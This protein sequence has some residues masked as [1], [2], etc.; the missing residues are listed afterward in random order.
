MLVVDLDGTLLDARGRVSAA[1]AA[2][3]RR[4]EEAGVEV[5]V[6][7]GRSWLESRGALTAI[8]SRGLM[9]GAGGATL[10]EAES[11]RILARRT[12]ET[13]LVERICDSLLR[14]GHLA[15]LLQDPEEAGRDYTLIGEAG[16]DP[17]S[18]WWFSVHPVRL[19]RHRS[20]D[21]A[22]PLGATIRVGTVA[23]DAE[24]ARVAGELREDLGDLVHLQHWSAQTAH[25]TI[26][27]RTHLLEI[28]SRDT[29]KWTMVRELLRTRD[30][31]PEAV[32]SVGDGLNDL[33]LVG[34]AGFGIAMGNAD[35]RV[36]AV[37]RATV[38]HHDRDGFAEA[39]DLLL[40][41]GS[42]P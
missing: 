35:P 25:E 4:A 40:G 1:N 5:V 7:T 42:R 24:L 28:F 11:G 20:I 39:V 37:A 21:E 16:L 9:I 31:G 41:A 22:R 6:A 19:H 29:N 2:A 14:H 3:V 34:S 36:A 33:Q 12:V 30:F 15:H 23:V 17:A 27:S 18:E 26:G 32:A 13:A 38:G 10:H 8:G